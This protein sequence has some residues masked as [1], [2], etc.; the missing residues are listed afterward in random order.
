M[1]GEIP[2]LIIRDEIEEAVN[3][4]ITTVREK[5]FPFLAPV[6]FDGQVVGI[7]LRMAIKKAEKSECP[8]RLLFQNIL[9]IVTEIY[10]D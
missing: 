4:S 8:K 9:D 10:K 1:C 5:M 6:N 7:L 3:K 2:M